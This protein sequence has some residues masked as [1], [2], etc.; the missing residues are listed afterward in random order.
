MENRTYPVDT[1]NSE[2]PLFLPVLS[3]STEPD[4]MDIAI[5][6]YVPIIQN[7]TF[8][9]THNTEFKRKLCKLR[10]NLLAK[11]TVLLALGPL[12]NGIYR[13]LFH[14]SINIYNIHPIAHPWVWGICWEWNVWS[15]FYL[16]TEF[17]TKGHPLLK[18]NLIR[19][20]DKLS[21]QPGCPVL[22]INVQENFCISQGNGSSS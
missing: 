22:H 11:L 20:S 3:F 5:L 8:L 17:Y 1:K 21:W 6:F 12:G 2:S 16:C 15:L 7:W 10:E 19:P 9:K 4:I 18:S 13:V 14:F